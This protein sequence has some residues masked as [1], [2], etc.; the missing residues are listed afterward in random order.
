MPESNSEALTQFG[1]NEELIAFFDSHDM[2]DYLSQMPEVEFQ[3]DI[4]RDRYLVSVDSSLMNSLLE[5][6]K[7]QKISV[8]LLVDAWLKE[9]LLKIG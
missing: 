1:S 2:G 6:A 4:K 8:E 9:K 5:T 3:V 7:D